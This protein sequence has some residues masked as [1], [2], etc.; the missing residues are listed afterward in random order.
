MKREFQPTLFTS[1]EHCLS[2]IGYSLAIPEG[3][4]QSVWDADGNQLK[5]DCSNIP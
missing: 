4:F 5:N 3:L 2:V 1:R